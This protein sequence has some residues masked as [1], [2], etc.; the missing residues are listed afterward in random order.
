MIVQKSFVTLALAL[1]RDVGASVGRGIE[2]F[3][4]AHSNSFCRPR[5]HRH[6]C[7]CDH[8]WV[9]RIYGHVHQCRLTLSTNRVRK[10]ECFALT[11]LRRL[12]ELLF[13]DFQFMG[14]LVKYRTV[15]LS[16]HII[17]QMMSCTTIRSG[18]NF[19][20]EN[21]GTSSYWVGA[22]GCVYGHRLIM[23]KPIPILG[24]RLPQ[25]SIANIVGVG[26]WIDIHHMIN[27]K[28]PRLYCL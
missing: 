10:Q 11:I 14:W 12:P 25:L 6:V 27:F 17:H 2:P 7:P 22:V 5:R 21:V 20:H 26:G 28:V 18:I 24:L 16:L 3:L 23:R 1:R 4:P 9:H 8:S 19:W 15:H 13:S